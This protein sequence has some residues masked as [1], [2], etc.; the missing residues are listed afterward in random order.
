ML[1]KLLHQWT[2]PS[3]DV[4]FHVPIPMSPFTSPQ[5]QLRSC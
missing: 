5:P 3:S 2:L 1:F 4:P